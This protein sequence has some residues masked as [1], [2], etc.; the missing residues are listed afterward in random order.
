MYKTPGRSKELLRLGHLTSE[1]MMKLYGEPT[2][3]FQTLNKSLT[4]PKKVYYLRNRR[5]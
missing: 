2:Q 1:E 3:G 5:L 4:N